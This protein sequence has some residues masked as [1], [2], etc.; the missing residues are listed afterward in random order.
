MLESTPSKNSIVVFRVNTVYHL[1][2]GAPK[3]NHASAFIEA[4]RNVGRANVV[5]VAPETGGGVRVTL[6]MDGDAV[7]LHVPSLQVIDGMDAVQHIMN[8]G[9]DTLRRTNRLRH[10]I[11]Q[12]AS[13]ETLEAAGLPLYW[14][15]GWLRQQLEGLGSYAAV[16]RAYGYDP[17][18]VAAYAARRHGMHAQQDMEATKR[19]LLDRWRSTSET[20]SYRQLA[21]E[22]G[23]SPTT[24]R[25]WILSETQRAS[26]S[27]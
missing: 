8:R 2:M 23:V 18:V 22:F 14:N 13:V 1:N 5:E 9:R 11:P 19:K 10:R 15:E 3:G 4:L 27:D 16:A 7:A 24:A 20:L 6:D 17:R 25:R 12:D 21:Q 26:P